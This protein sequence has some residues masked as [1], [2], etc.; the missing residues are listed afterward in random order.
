MHGHRTAHIPQTNEANFHNIPPLWLLLLPLL[1]FPPC[2][3]EK[4]FSSIALIGGLGILFRP[5]TY[6]CRF[7]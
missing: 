1:C 7:S 5:A 3:Q 6:F 4:P 2:R